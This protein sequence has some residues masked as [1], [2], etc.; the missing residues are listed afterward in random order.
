MSRVMEIIG[1][2]KGHQLV[3]ERLITLFRENDV[4]SPAN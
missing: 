2:P 4:A 3:A 1:P